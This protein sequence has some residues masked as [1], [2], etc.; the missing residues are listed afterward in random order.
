MCRG[1]V[2]QAGV[3]LLTR[4]LE[5]ERELMPT[6]ADSVDAVV[7]GDTHVDTTS[8]CVVS[9]VGAVLDQITI[10]N[11]EQGYAEVVTW[12]LRVV[13]SGRFLVGLEGTRSYGA[14]LCR[15][16]EAVGVR[17][18]EVERP[19]RGERGR[20]G[21]SDPG[22]AVL[23]A[24]KVLAMAVERVPEP[25]TGDGVREALRLLVV[26]REQ[27]T[28]QRTQLNNQLLA[29]LLTG[30]AE[31]QAMRRKSLSGTDLEKLAK[32]RCRSGRPIDEQARVA[33]LRRKASEIVRLDQQI[34]DNG[35]SLKTIIA[36][37]APQ[38]LEQVGVGPVV[39]A[40]LIVS[41]SHHGRCR[42]EAAFAAL[43]GV[44][45]VPASSGRIVRHRLN[46]GGDRQLNRALHTVAVTRA[47]WD[48][49][50]QAYIRRRSGQLTA[51]EIRRMLKRYIAREMFKI[52]RTVDALNPTGERAPLA[53]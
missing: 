51:K 18:V 13:P 44:S 25:R 45:P 32:A 31:H 39:A 49:R 46:R 26:D 48:E 27:M 37:V 34:R 10:D 9:P 33:V 7:G 23:A 21:K 15:A 14:G 12:I 53:A 30:T 50:T 28:R 47:Q 20:R 36:E 4:A 16:L 6:V 43:A 1:W 42:D 5:G 40:Q 29:E 17:V 19:S 22:D 2:L 38:L 8:L 41:Y 24:R 11:D 52:L 35:K 3:D